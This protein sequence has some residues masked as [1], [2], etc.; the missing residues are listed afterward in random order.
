[1]ATIRD[2]AKRAGVA[3]S[4]VSL[5]LNGKGPIKPETVERIQ[6]IAEEMGYVPSAMAQ[7]LRRGHNNKLIG[8]VLGDIGNPFFGKLLRNVD[9]VVAEADHMLIVADTASHADR[10]INTLNQ[11][12]R[13]RVGGIIMAPL[14]ND[15]AF[16]TYL[17]QIDVPVVLIDQYV[18]G[19]KLDFVTSDNEL[20]T[21][22]L[23]EYL[24]RLGHRRICYLGGQEQWWTAQLRLA[25][26]RK[27]MA[28]AGV[29]IDPA[30]EIMADFDGGKAYDQVARLLSL[31]NR[32]T[33][34][35]A[36][37]NLMALGALQAINDL[38]F[39]CPEDISL[40]GVDDVPWASVIQPRITTVVQ[41]V[42]ELARVAATWILERIHTRGG[43]A[44]APR[45]HVAMPRLVAG[46]SC[47]PPRSP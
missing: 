9:S 20:T 24:I 36:A 46:S 5:A 8:L 39:R 33:A 4:T 31:P 43:A 14:S 23:T 38:G 28:A 21:T 32:P 26:F 29:E 1:M 27:T 6:A 25:G 17:R 41:P 3:I 44:V 47:S 19:V 42:E 34:I 10:E 40:T 12:R 13:H 22:M 11:L 16:A 15:P 7:S 18:D 30:L 2:V 35:V 45:N 37:S